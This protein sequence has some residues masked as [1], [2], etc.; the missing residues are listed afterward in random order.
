MFPVA[1]KSRRFW[2]FCVCFTAGLHQVGGEFCLWFSPFVAQVPRTEPGSWAV[3]D[4]YSFSEWSMNWRLERGTQ[5]HAPAH[6]TPLVP[7]LR[8][9]GYR[10]LARM[11]LSSWHSPTSGTTTGKRAPT[12]SP[13]IW[14]AYTPAAQASPS[15]RSYICPAGFPL[16]RGFANSWLSPFHT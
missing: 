16:G 15:Q 12:G 1:L 2:L 9:P 14:G 8:G 7:D 10:T 11:L 6:V 13:W 4:K 3:F 5:T